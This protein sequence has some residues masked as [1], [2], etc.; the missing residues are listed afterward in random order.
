MSGRRAPVEAPPAAGSG[1]RHPRL[2]RPRHSRPTRRRWRL[3]PQPGVTVSY[4][5]PAAPWAAQVGATAGVTRLRAFLATR[6]VAALRRHRRRASTSSRSS[7]RSTGRSTAASTS[8]PRRWSTSTTATSAP[9]R[10]P[11]PPTCCRPRRSARRSSSPRP[12]RTSRRA[13]SRTARS[14]SSATSSSSSP[15]ARARR[16]RRS[17]RA[18]TR[19]AR[20]RPTRR[21]SKLTKRLEAKKDRLENAL[22]LAQRR[23][24][25]LDTQTKSRQ[26]NELIAGAGAVLGAL[27][28]GKRSARS[29]TSA[30]GSVA[31]KHGQTATSSERR[32]HRGGEGAADD[33]TTSPSSSRRSSTR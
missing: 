22:E 10:L 20:R 11:A 5:D 14:R 27:F 16:R 13:S 24:E 23:V 25:E 9:T 18:A 6:V 12:A 19:P 28:G 8:M 26:A 2:R 32:E 33:R 4:L 7:R 3:P 30:V 1:G 15:P 29:I 21:R 17:S 31:S